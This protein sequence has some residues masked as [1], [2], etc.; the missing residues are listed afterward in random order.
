[1][2]FTEEVTWHTFEVE[3]SFDRLQSSPAGLSAREA[4][5]RLSEHGQNALEAIRPRTLLAI[6]LDQF[7]DFMIGV[8]LVAAFVS[9]FIGEVTDT[10]AIIVI[11][12]LN[13]VIGF[14]QEYRSERAMEALRG[15]AAPHA[16][17]IRSGEVRGI[18]AA[19]VVP[20]D[21]VLLEAGMIVP[22]DL[23]LFEI[24]NLTMNESSLTGESLPVD[25]VREA[26]HDTYVPV[27]DRHNMAFSGTIVAAGRGSGVV[28]ATGIQ[29]QIGLIAGL[30]Q[31]AEIRTPLQKRLA[32]FGKSLALVVLAISV[33]VFLAGI[34]RGVEPTLMLLTAISLAVAA[35]PEALPAVVTISLALGAQ[36][37]VRKNALIRK[38]P[39]VETLGSVTFI[40]SD[41]TGTLTQNKM[42]VEELYLDAGR[43]TVGGEGYQ[44]EGGFFDETGGPV[45]IDAFAAGP[46]LLRNCLLCNNAA[47]NTDNKETGIVGDPTEA[48][49]LVLALKAGL[50]KQSLEAQFPRTGEVPFDSDRK[51]MTTVHRSGATYV[52]FTK[53]AVDV[54][55]ERLTDV[56]TGAGSRP[57]SADDKQ[58]IWQASET[59]A[60]DGLR[61]LATAA[62]FW[63]S[64]PD[65]AGETLEEQLVF[66]GLVGIMDPPRP[67]AISAVGRCKTAGIRPV[68]ITGDHPATARTIAERLAILEPGSRVVTGWELEEMSLAEF[69]TAV[70]DV[71]VYAR[72]SP[73]HKIKIVQALQDKGELVAMT[74]DGVNDA[75]ALKSADIGVAMGITGADV[76][77]ESADLVLLDD[78][79]ATIVSAVEGGRR[80]YDNIRRFIKYTMT[81]NSAEIWVMFL[82][83]FMGLPIPLLP[84]QILWVNLVTDGLPGLALAAEAAEVD[85][86]TRPPRHP[87]ES[88]F[89]HGMWQHMIW[90][91]LLMGGASLFSQAWFLR[92]GGSW[93][94]A[95]FSV[96]ALSQMGHALA[97]RSESLS[98]FKQ[99]LR[100]N[101]FL[102]LAVGLTLGLQ[103][104]IIYLPFLQNIF[105]TEGLSAGELALVLGLSTIVFFAVEVEK[106]VRRRR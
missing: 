24:A 99:G 29:S 17:V 75:P 80:I 91:G 8:L 52:S 97:V 50:D 36:E 83:P 7:K 49:M 79:F 44:V 47:L 4:E 15:L 2:S 11:I 21:I 57:L 3:D 20:G 6:F 86:M 30:I 35:I 104:M 56:W 43:L 84:I 5:K 10:I 26:I 60:G 95:I 74:G 16:T 69:E 32:R 88:I 59:I 18:P 81:S 68:M 45:A 9:G 61:V 31:V 55:F 87:K 76:A 100:S 65:V 39:A 41:K 22:A 78:N 85:I 101:M 62:R 64:E 12:I 58:A 93:Q 25:K 67:E 96:L 102:L 63:E 38:L 13:G 54:L 105:H 34:S 14:V 27:P 82:A 51:R 33:I 103:L 46:L 28:V 89:A 42:K 66:L 53:G 48:A 71:T 37:M 19:D 106:L 73:Q 77:K 72:V 40:C 90:V 92:T 70:R 23:R 98:L 94:T 1:M